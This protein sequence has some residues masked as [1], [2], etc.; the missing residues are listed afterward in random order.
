MKMLSNKEIKILKRMVEKQEK[1][2]ETKIS[3]LRMLEE[4]S[5]Y[6]EKHGETA[7]IIRM[8]KYLMQV[9]ENLTGERWTEVK[10]DLLP[11]VL[12]HLERLS[13]KTNKPISLLVDDAVTDYYMPII[14]R[15]L[16][17]DQRKCLEG[18]KE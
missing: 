5:R 6:T 7:K 16:Q 4:L 10:A 12:Y 3:L 13:K 1:L 8:K 18:G 15:E 9:L 2:E 14:L 11:L 17:Q